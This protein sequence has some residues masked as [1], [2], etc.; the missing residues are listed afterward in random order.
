MIDRDKVIKALECCAIPGGDC[1]ECPYRKYGVDEIGLE[2]ENK[3]AADALALLKAQEPR[4]MTLDELR[5]L[6][7]TDHIIWIEAN[8]DP[9][10]FDGY[11]EVTTNLITKDIEFFVPGNEVEFTPDNK[12]Y[13]KLWR[14]WT[15]KPTNKQRRDT[16]WEVEYD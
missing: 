11:A 12:N 1:L 15:S 5:Q 10:S 4:V 9:E 13:G 8:G 6:E 14:C 7:H 16:P 3:I 2:C